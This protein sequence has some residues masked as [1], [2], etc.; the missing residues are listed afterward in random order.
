MNENKKIEELFKQNKREFA[1]AAFEQK[2][3]DMLPVRPTY[4]REILFMVVIFIT[5]GLF[6]S[7]AGLYDVVVGWVGSIFT[8]VSAVTAKLTAAQS[9]NFMFIIEQLKSLCNL[10]SLMMLLVIASVI[11]GSVVTY[12]GLI[13]SD[14]G[15]V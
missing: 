6:I 5:F 14:R 7:F 2:I 9:G 11:F 10:H 13:Y 15:T 4:A 8:V 3:T 1:D 12:R